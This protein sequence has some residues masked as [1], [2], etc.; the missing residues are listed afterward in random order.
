M[1]CMFLAMS[2]HGAGVGARL[3][4]RSRRHL[5]MRILRQAWSHPG[6]AGSRSRAIMRALA[7]QMR[8][9]L[10]RGE[11]SISAYGLTLSFPRESGSLSNYFYFGESFEWPLANFM[12]AYVRD[13]DV[14]IDAG[15]NVGMF[16]YLAWECVRP[17]GRIVAFEPSAVHV[18][19][20][21]SNARKNRLSRSIEVH[22]TAVGDV[23]GSALFSDDLDVSNRLT[24]HA[25]AGR[26]A[27][28]VPVIRI[29][30]VVDP[31][32]ALIKLDVE[33]AEYIALRGCEQLVRVEPPPV[34]VVEAHDHS[35]RRLGSSRSEVIQLLDE[36]GFQPVTFEEDSRQVQQ[37][38]WDEVQG[39]AICVHETQLE[40]VRARVRHR[41]Q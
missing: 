33:G 23:Q 40:H 16:T 21:T 24:S 11:V 5:A 6:N 28:M 29:D 41:T 22:A 36:W 18:E 4:L 9:R 17:S 8:K 1:G 19:V 39:D 15:A 20:I 14:V 12:R 31:P 27:H 37:C 30:Q 34:I 7:W 3:R 25:P 2:A 32:V 35:L 10:G 13:G 26:S 38:H